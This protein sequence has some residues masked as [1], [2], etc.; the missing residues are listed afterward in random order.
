M[1]HCFHKKKAMP[2]QS[3]PVAACFATGTSFSWSISGEDLFLSRGKILGNCWKG[4]WLLGIDNQTT[5]SCHLFMAMAMHGNTWHMACESLLGT[6]FSW[7]F[8]PGQNLRPGPWDP[9]RPETEQP[10]RRQQKNASK[11][12]TL[13]IPGFYI[14]GWIIKMNISRFWSNFEHFPSHPTPPFCR[15]AT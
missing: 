12:I 5:T 10:S 13:H 8:L 1:T 2:I 9:Y 3:E 4:G 6:I 7:P 14:S 15:P 11:E